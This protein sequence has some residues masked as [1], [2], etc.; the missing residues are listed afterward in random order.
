MKALLFFLIF[1]PT[2]SFADTVTCKDI[3]IKT[4]DVQGAR[5]DGM[6]FGNNL[7]VSF[8]DGG[9]SDYYCG[10]AKYAHLEMGSSLTIANS[11][12]SLALSAKVADLEVSVLV[13]TSDKISTL[14]NQLSVISIQ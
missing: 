14:S 2:I 12:L 6:A 13:N 4:V 10:G 8:K 11:L 9:G 1:I 5:D 7:V 3:Y